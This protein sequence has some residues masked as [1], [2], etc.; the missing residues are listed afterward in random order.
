MDKSNKRIMCLGAGL[1]QLPLIR[2]AVNM[3]LFVVTVD[4]KPE[5]PG[6]KISD[7]YVN[8]ST[9]DKNCVLE[10]AKRL[11]IDGITTFAS[12]VAVPSVSFVAHELELPGGDFENSQ[13][14]Y[15]KGKF[16]YFQKR[17]G[18]KYPDFLVAEDFSEIK[19]IIKDLKKPLIFKPVDSSGSRGISKLN[20]LTEKTSEN[21]F[22]NAKIHSHSG[23]V[24]VEEFIEG[25][26]VGG[27]AFLI[28]STVRAVITH[29]HIDNFV[30]VGHELPTNISE[31][32]QNKV[33]EEL[34]VTC[35]NLN[36]SNGPLNFDVI[37]SSKG[38]YILEM[39]SRLG[40]NGIPLLV[41]RGTGADFISTG[42]NFSIGE[43]LKLPEEMKI[44]GKCGSWVFGSRKSGII[45]N[46]A[47]KEELKEKVPEVFDCI[48]NYKIGD[49]VSEFL[50]SGNQI[51]YVLFDCP[52]DTNYEDITSRIESSLALEISKI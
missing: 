7:E 9:M 45:T 25:I 11:K 48:I 36:Y 32:D 49:E 23:K 20:E 37:V 8:C 40:G 24:C 46:I 47:S 6:H 35:S 4:Y 26:E 52:P 50:H 17:H 41:H 16:R 38:V 33:I 15:D 1:S 27:D 5:N 29:K 34:S 21:A 22:L 10:A 42:I 13:T 2:K 14:L 44:R 51:G 39:S 12:N 30:P 3:G 18:L 28:D 43:E 31:E 19:N